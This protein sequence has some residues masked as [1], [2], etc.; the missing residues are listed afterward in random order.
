M[1]GFLYSDESLDEDWCLSET[2]DGC[3]ARWNLKAWV[4]EPLDVA[5]MLDVA[6]ERLELDFNSNKGYN[7]QLINLETRINTNWKKK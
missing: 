7:T 1:D 5:W 2:L 6:L 4:V 3:T